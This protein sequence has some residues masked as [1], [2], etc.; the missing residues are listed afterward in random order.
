LNDR[1]SF[2]EREVIEPFDNTYL[3]EEIPEFRGRGRT[4]K[5]SASRFSCLASFAR[6]TRARA[7]EEKTQ[8]EQFE[9]KG[10]PVGSN[11]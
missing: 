10:A 7:W 2:G 9:Y 8:P 4:P 1:D 11:S 6:Q 5:I 3:T